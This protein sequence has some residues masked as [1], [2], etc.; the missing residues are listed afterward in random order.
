MISLFI[1]AKDLRY[2]LQVNVDI[3]A[4][5]EYETMCLFHNHW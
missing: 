4:Y 3:P 2:I 1:I 5:E